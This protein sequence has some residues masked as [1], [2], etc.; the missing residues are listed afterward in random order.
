MPGGK[1]APQPREII[2]VKNKENKLVWPEKEDFKKGKRRFKSDLVPAAIL[3]ARYFAAARDGIA[4]IEAELA[5]IEQQ[6][7]ETRAEHTGEERT[8]RRSQ[9]GK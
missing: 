3:I 5:G 1:R 7:D 6:L 9:R 4:A 8:A 2:Q